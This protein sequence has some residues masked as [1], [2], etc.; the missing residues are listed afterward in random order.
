MTRTSVPG[1]LATGDRTGFT[2]GQAVTA[3]GT[4]GMLGLE[5][6]RYID[7]HHAAP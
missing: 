6:R 5:A 7:A 3:A 2:D 4:G 1:V